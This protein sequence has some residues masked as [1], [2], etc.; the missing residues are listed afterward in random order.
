MGSI[1]DW[2]PPPA[3]AI[4]N[5]FYR[6]MCHLHLPPSIDFSYE[7]STPLYRHLLISQLI[8]TLI[9]IHGQYC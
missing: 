6:L 4:K 9:I 3:S 2:L 5:V 1:G 8:A 7:L